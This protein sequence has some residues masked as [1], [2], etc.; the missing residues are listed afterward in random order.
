MQECIDKERTGGL[1]KKDLPA[2][3][4]STLE[5]NIPSLCPDIRHDLDRMKSYAL[6][7]VKDARSCQARPSSTTAETTSRG[8][9]QV[10]HLLPENIS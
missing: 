8:R 1:L 5:N 7:A 10:I 4:N 2:A 6:N 9:L 3:T